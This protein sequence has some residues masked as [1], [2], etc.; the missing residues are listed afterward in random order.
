MLKMMQRPGNTLSPVI[1]DAWD[2]YSLRSLT[3]KP[4]AVGFGISRPEQ[5]R[6]VLGIP[7]DIAVVELMSVGYP[8]DRMREPRRVGVEKIVCYEKWQF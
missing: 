2:G 4:V 8:A 7:D 6:A 1:R 5:V 3:K